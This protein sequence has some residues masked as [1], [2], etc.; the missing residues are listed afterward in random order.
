MDINIIGQGYNAAAE[1]SAGHKLVKLF[2]DEALHSFTGISAFASVAGV[3][4]LAALIENARPHL[5]KVAVIV[6]ID[7][8]GTSKEALEELLALDVNSYIFYQPGV[9]IFHPKIYLFEGDGK[10]EVIIGSSNLTAQGL[11]ANVEASVHLS[12]DLRIE[13]ERNIVQ[14]LKGSFK[15]LFD[16]SDPNLKRLDEALIAVLSDAG[17][18]PTEAERKVLQEQSR[19]VKSDNVTSKIFPKRAA[20]G[21]PAAFSGRKVRRAAKTPA[22]GKN[23]KTAIPEKLV[24]ESGALTT[25]DLNIPKGSVTNPTGSMLFKKGQTKDIDQRHYFRDIVFTVLNWTPDERPQTAHL[26]R[27][28]ALFTIVIEGKNAGTFRLSLTHNTR[29]DTRAYSQR[30]SMTQIHWGSAKSLIAREN[31]IGKN[32]RLFTTGNA[33]EFILEIG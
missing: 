26:E 18:V 4:G 16:Y 23:Q 30:N 6:G 21:I 20:A 28:T 33:G 31:L 11:F 22:A 2:S 5:Q 1:N 19:A 25:R 32:A 10:A 3:R 17:L 7:Q 8:K 15:G 13:S 14:Q 29:T 9:S 12:L 24:W 27:A